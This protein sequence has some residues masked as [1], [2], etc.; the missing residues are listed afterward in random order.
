MS[1]VVRV[2]DGFQP[3]LVSPELGLRRLVQES[4]DLVMDPVTTAV[5]RIHQILLEV[6]RYRYSST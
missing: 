6:A 1:Q 3:H 4:I 5:R 2:S